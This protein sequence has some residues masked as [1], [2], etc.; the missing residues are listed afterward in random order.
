MSYNNSTHPVVSASHGHPVGG[1][2]ESEAQTDS[3]VY[4]LQ[5]FIQPA[6]G[7]ATGAYPYVDCQ[8]PSL[9]QSMGEHQDVSQGFY[10]PTGYSRTSVGSDE[11]VELVFYA[12]YSAFICR[13]G[14]ERI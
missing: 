7:G 5:H 3:D 2:A 14:A 12:W 8:D 11:T 13:R 9:L 1:M 10:P 4:W 6:E